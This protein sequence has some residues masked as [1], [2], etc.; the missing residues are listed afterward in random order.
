MTRGRAFRLGLIR[1]VRQPWRLVT[2]IGA[3]AVIGAVDKFVDGKG[4]GWSLLSIPVFVVAG[5]AVFVAA[6]SPKITDPSDET[7]ESRSDRG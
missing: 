7:P 5:V 3:G 6:F 2:I 1:L 4:T